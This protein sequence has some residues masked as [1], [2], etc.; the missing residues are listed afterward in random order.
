LL[1]LTALFLS[2]TAGRAFWVSLGESPFNMS[3]S[4]YVEFFQQLVVALID[5]AAVIDRILRH[6]CLPTE[7]PAARPARAP[8]LVATHGSQDDRPQTLRCLPPAREPSSPGGMPDVCLATTS[9][10]PVT[11]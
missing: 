11:R 2:L 6:L 9:G 10:L 8:P 3:G 4:T 5:Q 1:F 7:I